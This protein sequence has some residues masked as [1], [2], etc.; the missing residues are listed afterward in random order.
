MRA[1]NE[2][3]YQLKVTL[4]HIRPPIWRRFLVSSDI[5]FYKLHLIL[6]EV[7]GWA[8]YHLYQFD[9][10]GTTF[11]DAETVAELGGRDAT[12]DKLNRFVQREGDKFLYE[13]DFG[14]DWQHEIVL[15]KVLTAEEGIHYPTAL[16]GK[17]A[18]PPEDVGG[19]WGYA[20]FLEAIQ[21]PAHDEYEA[22]LEWIGG[23]FDTE[24]FDL[25]AVNR[26]LQRL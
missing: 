26:A 19:P 1:K 13:Y 20:M 10:G 15:E 16:K 4:K 23:E 21:N 17:R 8:N 9:V 24:A 14:D 12:K 2:T 3:I 6:Q 22:M 18:C 5:T 7:M 11:T 25:N